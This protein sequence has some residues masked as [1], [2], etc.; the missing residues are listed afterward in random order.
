[1]SM[2]SPRRALGAAEVD[3]AVAV[4]V[5]GL[6]MRDDDAFAVEE[7]QLLFAA[8][9]ALARHQRSCLP[10]FV[11]R[12]VDVLV[13]D[14]VRRPAWCCRYS[15]RRRR[16]P[17]R[18]SRRCRRRRSGSSL[19]L[20]MP[21]IGRGARGPAVVGSSSELLHHW[22][23]CGRPTHDFS[24]TGDA[25]TRRDSSRT[26]ARVLSDISADARVHQQHAVFADGS[27]DV[28]AGAAQEIDVPAHRAGP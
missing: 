1:M 22:H 18:Q 9:V 2:T 24:G 11:S 16:A 17:R 8:E 23:P 28:G 12:S 26:A 15:G 7:V 6:G 21:L 5:R 10:S 13:R 20:T 14:D 19:V 25:V 3:D 27:D 4:G